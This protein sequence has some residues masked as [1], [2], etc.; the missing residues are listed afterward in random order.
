MELGL[1]MMP[2]HPPGRPAAETYRE[3][4]ELIALADQLGFREA[5]IGEHGT[6]RWE[7]IPAPDQF[8]AYAAARTERIRFGTGV[9]MMAQHHPANTANRLAQLDHLTRG[10][11]M[12]GAGTGGVATDLELFGLNP[13]TDEV[14]QRMMR[15]L[16]L[17]VKFWTEEPP[18]DYPG[19]YWPI[20][21]TGIR[22]DVGLGWLLK[23]Y[24]QPHPPIALPGVGARSRLLHTAGGRGYLPLS[25]NFAH[26]RV[27]Q[28]HWEQVAAGAAEAGRT[29]D[30]RQWRI[31]RDI[32]VGETTAEARRFAREGALGHAFREYWSRMLPERSREVFL[33]REDMPLSEWTLDYVM[34]NVWLVGDP[35]EVAR[36][37]R[38]LYDEVGGFGTLLMI[39]HDWDEPARWQR[40]VELLA[41]EVLPRLADLD[42]A[43][44]TR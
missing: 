38:H 35:D 16:D 18:Y 19:E 36:Q 44:G 24:Q 15:A 29:A 39:G 31:A 42:V 30:R 33:A 28:G 40:S 1:F 8:I 2:L 14:G 21:V 43:I 20:K 25:T 34:D 17:I 37:V 12:F 22:H 11:I 23:P 27:L 3:D 9:V 7:N 5:W 13:N 26:R 32:F 6:M 10:R 4:I 41:T